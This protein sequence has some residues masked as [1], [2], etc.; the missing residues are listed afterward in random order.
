M[1]GRVFD[2]RFERFGRKFDEFAVGDTYKHWPGKTITEAED[3]LF[4]LLTMASSPLHIDSHYAQ[5][6]MPNGRNL[7]V[8][9]YVYSLLLG[10]SVSGTSGAAVAA[11]GTDELRH[12]APVF[13][14]DTLYAESE[15]IEARRSQ[16][17]PETGVITIA[18]RGFNQEGVLVCRFRRSFLV[19]IAT[20]PDDDP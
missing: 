5:K 20:A 16:T 15:V 7:V 19:P 4:C 12:T 2:E 17:R 1:V 11:L 13:H 3:H 14:G 9:T 10:M 18:T 8:G 6:E